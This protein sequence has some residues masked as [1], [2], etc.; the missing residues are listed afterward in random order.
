MTSGGASCLGAL[1]VWARVSVE[2]EA[3]LLHHESMSSS[4]ELHLIDRFAAAKSHALKEDKELSQS[5]RFRPK[6]DLSGKADTV[7][8]ARDDVFS[9]PS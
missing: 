5:R 7:R 3:V 8:K 2:L 6:T 9:H 4:V 1:A